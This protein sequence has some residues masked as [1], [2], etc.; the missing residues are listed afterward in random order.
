MYKVP[1]SRARAFLGAG[2]GALLCLGAGHA[3]ADALVVVQLRNAAGSPA[4]G[5]VILETADGKH[6][7]DC[8]TAGGTC[9]MSG[10]PGGSYKARVEPKTGKAP[11]PRTV[12]IPPTGKVSLIVNTEG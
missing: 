9:E 11:K 8:S 5:K 4:D 7:A 2:L 3:R 6:V 10:V 1:V 12:M